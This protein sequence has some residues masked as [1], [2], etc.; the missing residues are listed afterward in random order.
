LDE[1]R[2]SPIT[3]DGNTGMK[4]S[5]ERWNQYVLTSGNDLQTMLNA[6]FAERERNLVFILGKGFDP[7]MN[8][9]V[10]A[11]L[12]AGGA[13]A[14]AVVLLDFDEG[15]DSPSVSYEPRVKRNVSELEQLI[16]TRCKLSVNKVQMFSTERRRIVARSA[17]G[18]ITDLNTFKG[19]TDYVVDVSSLPRGIFY[20]LI[21][22][23]LHLIDQIPDAKQKPNLMILVGESAALDGL[24]TDDGID[25]DADYLHPFRG[26]AEREATAALPKV[27][28]PILGERQ[29]VQLARINDLVRPDEICVVLPSPSINPRRGDDLI[30][31]Y[32]QLLYDELMVDPRNFVFASELNPFEAYKQLRRAI[33]HYNEALMPLG[34]CRSILTSV[35]SKLLSLSALLAAYEL[36]EAHFDI[37]VA[38][39]E[40]DGYKIQSEDAAIEAAT[41]RTSLFGLWL[42]GEFYVS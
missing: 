34:G 33:V 38:H 39:I 15:P 17:A 13:G 20:P 8:L 30:L 14:R 10:K 41:E 32:R 27:W 19:T 11:V 35:S 5:L 21:A 29:A 42:T 2:V 36:K 26:G 7:R 24:I 1:Q 37:S 31:E 25:E 12:S 40:C 22:K 18:L 6:H 23:L 3:Q 16:G 4:S 28:L 9:G